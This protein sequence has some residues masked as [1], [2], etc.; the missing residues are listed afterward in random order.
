MIEADAV[1]AMQQPG[2]IAIVVR[3]YTPIRGGREGSAERRAHRGRP[4]APSGVTSAA[5][6]HVAVLPP[7]DLRARERRRDRVRGVL[8]GGIRMVVRVA[9]AVVGAAA[10]PR[11]GDGSRG[12]GARRLGAR[13]GRRP[14]RSPRGAGDR[15]RGRR[16][17]WIAA[18]WV[19][20]SG[21]LAE[22]LA[23]AEED[24]ES[25]QPRLRVRRPDGLPLTGARVAEPG[26]RV[27]LRLGPG[28]A[29]GFE[30]PLSHGCDARSLGGPEEARDSPLDNGH[31]CTE[32]SAVARTRHT[33][34]R[35]VGEQRAAF[36]RRATVEASAMR[37]I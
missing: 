2:A 14:D 15:D 35:D 25:R 22:E 36:A 12:A 23:E 37:A 8:R 7:A 27:G 28:R 21:P 33:D 31:D 19:W 13:A 34:P 9:A 5:R 18:L 30:S 6:T 16:D 17:R 32:A 10:R 1:Q 3:P 26:R 4:A 11:A 29:W 24:G 20:G